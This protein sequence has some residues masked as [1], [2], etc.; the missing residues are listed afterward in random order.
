M[1]KRPFGKSPTT[2][3]RVEVSVRSR[4]ACQLAHRHGPHAHLDP[5]LA[6][7]AH[8]WQSNVAKLTEEVDRSDE[9]FIKHLRASYSESLPPVRAVCEVMSLGLLSRWYNNL[10]PMPTRRAIAATYGV[11][12]K[13]LESWLR[14]LSLVRNTCAHHSRLWNR[15]FTITPLLPRHKPAGLGLQC[16]LG[17]RKL[18]NSL[19]LLLHF[20]DVIAP[21]HHWRARLKHLLARHAIPVAAMDFPA[22]RQALAIWQE[23][24]P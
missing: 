12:E 2:I 22:D 21:R 3:E 19:V 1:M 16:R 20:M 9:V 14:H 18:Y 10:R 23:A 6:F 5:G 7:K 11:D 24:S 4:W 8:H 17:S 13:V 15:E